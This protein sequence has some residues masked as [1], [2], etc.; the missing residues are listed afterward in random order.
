MEDEVLLYSRPRIH[1][2]SYYSYYALACSKYFDDIDELRM[3]AWY[4]NGKVKLS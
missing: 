4:C 1:A 2:N 3:H